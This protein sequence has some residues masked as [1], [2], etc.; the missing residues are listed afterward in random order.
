MADDIGKM[1]DRLGKQYLEDAEKVP[2]P[3]VGA[4]MDLLPSKAA[5]LDV[6]CAGGR[7]TEKFADRGFDVTG[8]DASAFFIEE[9]RKRIPV[10]HFLK[11]DVRTFQF[12]DES[13]DAIWA[14]AVLLHIP[15]GDVPLVLDKFW[16]VLKPEGK[17]HIAVKVGEGERFV[18]DVFEHAGAV[19]RPFTFFQ[20]NE[21]E[22]LVSAA[23][24]SIV[25]SRV[26]PDD[27][28]RHD[29]EWVQLWAQK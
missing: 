10:G 24:F 16:H 15:R 22:K 19:R 23:G 5:V 6:G 20:Q 26:V 8:I 27:Q 21:L 1:Y 25:S 3:D 7:D 17:L 12:P 13:F 28:G 11:E 9:A 14:H 2:P 4:F 18:E 29:V